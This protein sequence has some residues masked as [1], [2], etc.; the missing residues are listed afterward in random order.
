MIS[1]STHKMI[2]IFHLPGYYWRLFFV[3]WGMA[4][5]GLLA[6]VPYVLALQKNNLQAVHL[7]IPLAALISIQVGVQV[8][9]LGLI[10]GLGIWFAEKVDLGAPILKAWIKDTPQKRS[11]P[12]NWLRYV[13]I[14]LAISLI[15]VLLDKLVFNPLLQS[16][17]QLSELNLPAN[18]NPPAWEGFLASFYGGFTEEILIRLFLMSFLAWLGSKIFL[19]QYRTQPQRIIW[20][21]NILSALVFGLGHLPTAVSIGYPLSAVGIARILV[22]NSFPGLVFGWLYWKRG[23]ES[24]MIAHFSGDILLHVVTAWLFL[25]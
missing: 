6:G 25:P 24:A 2:K 4:S 8:L 18:I 1:D 5:F 3:L 9:I 16:Q 13:G 12:L 11:H 23:I 14:G 17:T 20:T 22:L 7:H 15:I 10:T 19:N 21:A